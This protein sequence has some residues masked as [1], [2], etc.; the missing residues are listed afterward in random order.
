MPKIKRVFSFIFLYTYNRFFLCDES[1]FYSINIASTI[2]NLFLLFDFARVKIF[3]WTLCCLLLIF[4]WR[5]DPIGG[6]WVSVMAWLWFVL[7]KIF[8]CFVYLQW[9]ILWV[10]KYIHTKRFCY[11]LIGSL[12][13]I[14]LF[15]KLLVLIFVFTNN[16]CDIFIFIYSFCVSIIL[17][18]SYFYISVSYFFVIVMML[19]MILVL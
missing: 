12:R 17:Y 4:W 10:V 2:L 15:T 7:C 18:I 1:C 8:V 16:E 14:I 6:K 5:S 19:T 9:N 13:Y 3:L 11:L